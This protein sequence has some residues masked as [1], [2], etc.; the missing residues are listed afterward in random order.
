MLNE[1]SYACATTVI[2]VTYI[3]YNNA[4]SSGITFMSVNEGYKS[5]ICVC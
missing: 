2:L 4:Y 3:C 5:C 1:L